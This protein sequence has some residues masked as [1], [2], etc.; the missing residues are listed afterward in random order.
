MNASGR[1][2]AKQRTP[3][4][5]AALIETAKRSGYFRSYAGRCLI[6]LITP[7]KTAVVFVENAPGRFASTADA[8]GSF[9]ANA[10]FQQDGR[11]RLR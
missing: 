3:K 7:P 11:L 10:D 1:R 2:A 4:A 5:D 9:A 8:T 6:W